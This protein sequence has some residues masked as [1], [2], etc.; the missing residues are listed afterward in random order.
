MRSGRNQ[1]ARW[2]SEIKIDYAICHAPLQGRGRAETGECDGQAGIF[3][4]RNEC[5]KHLIPPVGA[6]LFEG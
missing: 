2:F 6:F 3:D 4:F 1:I 5:K